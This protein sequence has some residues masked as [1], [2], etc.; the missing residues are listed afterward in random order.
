MV[1]DVKSIINKKDSN[2]YKN[3]INKK[4]GNRYKK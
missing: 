2:R 1:I 4:D 3:I